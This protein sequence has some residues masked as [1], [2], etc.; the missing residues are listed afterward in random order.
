MDMNWQPI[1]GKAT[2]HAS[3]A[4]QNHE[5]VV[6]VVKGQG[7]EP[8]LCKQTLLDMNMV[9]ILNCD[10]EP[11]VS[12]LAMDQT[13]L[14]DEYSDVFEGLGRL[15]GPYSI[16]TDTSVPPVVHP[17]RRIPVALIDQ[18]QQ[19]LDEMV[20]EDVIEKVDQPTDWVSSMLVVRKPATGSTRETKI[21]VC[22]D[23]RDLNKAIKREHFPMPTIA[24]IGGSECPSA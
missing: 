11:R 20:T 15:E 2:M 16:V 1:E 9:Q 21:R 13:P 17:P 10:R 23:P 12:T 24:E 5:I 6:N 22:L 8:I 19:K 14:L 3:R 7:Y 18:V 4:G